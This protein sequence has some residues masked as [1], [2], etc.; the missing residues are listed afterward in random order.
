MAAHRNVV[1]RRGNSTTRYWGEEKW[2]DVRFSFAY[3]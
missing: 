2:L 1:L 3:R